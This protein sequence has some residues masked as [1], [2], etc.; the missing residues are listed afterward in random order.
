LL[1]LTD[2][3]A[4]RVSEIPNFLGV[5]QQPQGRIEFS[6]TFNSRVCLC[7]LAY[8]AL[9]EAVYPIVLLFAF[10]LHLA[11]I[12]I[13][14]EVAVVC[15]PAIWVLLSPPKRVPAPARPAERAESTGLGQWAD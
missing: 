4:A 5:V 7:E 12:S 3:K 1:S 2:W 10:L 11:H 9:R 6:T 13:G 14:R 15:V 8:R